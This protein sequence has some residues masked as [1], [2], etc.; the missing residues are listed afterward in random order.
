MTAADG[1][2]E[3]AEATRNPWA[4]SF[5]LAAYAIAFGDAYPDRA[6]DASA[7]AWWSLKKAATASS[8]PNWRRSTCRASRGDLLFAFDHFSLAIR[9]MHDSANTT[10]IRSPLA[11]LATVLDRLG[12]YE[13][14]ATIAGFASGPL[15]E[16]AYP[17]MI[18]A[19]AHLRDVLDDQ[20][21]ESLAREGETMSTSAMAT[22]AYDQ[23][24]QAR[25]ELDGVSKETTYKSLKSRSHSCQL[26]PYRL[27]RNR[28]G[29]R[30]R[31]RIRPDALEQ[32]KKPRC[33]AAATGVRS[34]LKKTSLCELANWG[35]SRWM[36]S[37]L[38]LPTL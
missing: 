24:D 18:T 8:N 9:N 11:L 20:T 30:P 37:R 5:V 19:I 36:D 15:T 16:M 27:C 32:V 3:A 7:G 12:R 31:E 22:Y 6:L 38:R 21:Y 17:E 14:A 35:R 33:A 10:T 4:I 23:I 2:I 26:S 13:S 25:A 34:N 1:L 28:A 29:N